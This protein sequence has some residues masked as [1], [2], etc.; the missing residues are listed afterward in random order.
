[1]DFQIK[2]LSSSGKGGMKKISK[3]TQPTLNS[4]LWMHGKTVSFC[5]Q[6]NTPQPL[7]LSP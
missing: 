6:V 1:M 2:K 3:Q 5:P 7:V 4:L